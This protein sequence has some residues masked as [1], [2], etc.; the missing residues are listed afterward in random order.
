MKISNI[1]VGMMC[2]YIYMYD[3][4]IQYI[5]ITYVITLLWLSDIVCIWKYRRL[6]VSKR[7]VYVYIHML[8]VYK[9]KNM[10][11]VYS[12]NLYIFG[13]NVSRKGRHIM[14]CSSCL[15]ST[16]TLQDWRRLALSNLS[17]CIANCCHEKYL[18]LSALPIPADQTQENDKGK[19]NK[20]GIWCWW[21]SS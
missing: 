9:Q 14:R 21:W 15:W 6:F 11:T 19:K 16:C 1:Y 7:N 13:I 12:I 17:I 18:F 3:V 10:F 5:Y 20:S 8:C 2:I 4:N